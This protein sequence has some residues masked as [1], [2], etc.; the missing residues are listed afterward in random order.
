M[1][2]D[3]ASPQTYL[4]LLPIYDP[5]AG[6]WHTLNLG[7]PLYAPQA[8]AIR[9]EPV[10]KATDFTVTSVGIEFNLIGRAKFLHMPPGW[11]AAFDSA[12]LH[13]TYKDM[14]ALSAFH[15]VYLQLGL[16]TRGRG[17]RGASR[18]NREVRDFLVAAVLVRIAKGTSQR[19]A[20]CEVVTEY[21]RLLPWPFR[22]AQNTLW[23]LVK[24]HLART[25]LSVPSPPKRVS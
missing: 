16:Q 23:T 21:D 10:M 2:A 5:A 7:M 17:E 1:S 6:K 14:A 11:P 13:G 3:D 24:R 18:A 12:G 25:R 22:A 20:V 15:A 19:V 4:V 8:E 9:A